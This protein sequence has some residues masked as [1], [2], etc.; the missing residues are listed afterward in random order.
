MTHDILAPILIFLT[1]GILGVVVFQRLKLSPIIGFFAAGATIGPY[2]ANWVENTQD[3]H[4]LAELGVAFLLFDVG[5][6]L[7]FKKLWESRRDLLGLGPGQIILTTL[8]LSGLGIVFGLN[9]KTALLIGAGLSL[10]S[11]AVVLQALKER[12]E[13]SSPLANASVGVLIAQD[14]FVVFLLVLVPALVSGTGN[15]TPAIAGAL[16]KV[17]LAL[18][19]VSLVGRFL[20]RPYFEKITATKN[21]EVFTASALLF[22]LLTAWCVNQLGLS[23]PLGAF[24]AGLALS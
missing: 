22:V 17:L 24:L 18:V 9:L 12:D 10:S 14:I 7:S 1:A 2:G 8:L 13:Q 3:L 11:T 23:L 5:L 21:D 16:A 6:H 19:V 4:L 15:L 20:L